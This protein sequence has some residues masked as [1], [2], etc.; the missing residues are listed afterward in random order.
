MIDTKLKVVIM[1]TKK[2]FVYGTLKEG[3]YYAKEFD[4]FRIKTKSA[5][6]NGYD[7]F[8]LG[9]F[10]GIIPGDGKV[11]GELHE[12]KDYDKVQSLM[13]SIE[14]YDE[15]NEEDS[16]YLRKNALVTDEDGEETTAVVYVFNKKPGIMSEKV[17]G[18]VW[19]LSKYAS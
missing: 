15:E 9:W 19:D 16:L 4:K 11:V 8:N 1:S 3:G 5:K 13:D 18:G 17:D 7:L 6:L 10:P 2:F 14:G 12:Y